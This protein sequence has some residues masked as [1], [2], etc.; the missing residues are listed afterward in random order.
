MNNNPVASAEKEESRF[1]KVGV[2][3]L[4]HMLNDFYANYL[5]QMIPFLAITMTGFNATKATVLTAAFTITSSLVQ[6]IFGLWLDRHGKRW[7][8]YVGTL[9]MAIMLSM[10][11]LTDSYPM[12]VVLAALAGM[13]TAVFHPQASSMVNSLSS[14]HKGIMMSVFVTAGNLGFALSPLLLIPLFQSFGLQATPITIIPGALA[15]LLLFVFAPRTKVVKNAP[16]SLSAVLKSVNE[17]RGELLAIVGVIGIRSAAYTAVL[18]L[19]PLYFQSENMDTTIAGHLVAI[20]LACGAIGGLIGG[21]LSDR[22]GRKPLIVS[23]LLLTAPLFLGFLFTQGIASVIFLA[24]GGT[25]LLSSFSVTVVAAQEAIPNSKALAS[26]ISL[27]FAN[28]VGGLGA[29]ALGGVADAWGL[30]TALIVVF[31]LPLA[32]ALC[33]LFM[34][35]RPSDASLRE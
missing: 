13:G 14:F 24:L 10:T 1:L 5:P 11:G 29:I 8:V 34:K 16:T 27:G 15:A 33:G 18:T 4:A 3:S 28:G 31:L 2:L 12:L 25:M 32:A 20:M 35:N 26:G 30:E 22:F 21:F 7:L 6:P 17:V 23:S 19:L 9:W